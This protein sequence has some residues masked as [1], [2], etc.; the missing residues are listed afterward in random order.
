MKRWTGLLLAGALC[1]LGSA[2]LAADST[3]KKVGKGAEQTGKTVVH[4]TTGVGKGASKIYHEAAKGV[5]KVIAK[6]SKSSTTKS[7]HMGKAEL[8]DQHAHAKAHQSK[9]EI[10]RAG[11]EGDKITKPK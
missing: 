4:G 2:S 1:T 5:H 11:E 9:K 8:H 10:R 6:N 7:K 3:A